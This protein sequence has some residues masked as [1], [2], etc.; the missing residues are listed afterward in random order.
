MD[1]L[2]SRHF[3]DRLLV[4]GKSDDQREHK[5]YANRNQVRRQRT[6]NVHDVSHVDLQHGLPPP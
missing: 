3:L 2:T 5:Y 1:D 4:D 6:N